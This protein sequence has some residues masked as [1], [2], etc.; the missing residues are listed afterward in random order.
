MSE[1]TDPRRSGRTRR[2]T[3]RVIDSSLP[4]QSLS[5]RPPRPVTKAQLNVESVITS[6]TPR[7][8]RK[9]SIT[10]ENAPKL[11]SN[12]LSASFTS[13]QSSARI[14]VLRPQITPKSSEIE[15]SSDE[16][17][18]SSECSSS[19]NE[20]SDGDESNDEMTFRKRDTRDY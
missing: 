8:D 12:L 13:K 14:P 2:P 20:T 7:G 4:S 18:S 11:N 15:D 17:C 10:L 5:I 9:K 16:T 1:Q 3:E 19:E 6:Q